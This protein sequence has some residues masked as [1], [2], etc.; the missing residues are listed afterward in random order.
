[1][2]TSNICTDGCFALAL[3]QIGHVL[4][5][6]QRARQICERSVSDL[7][8]LHEVWP[9]GLKQL[10]TGGHD[11]VLQN[12]GSAGLQLQAQLSQGLQLPLVARP[13]RRAIP[14]SSALQAWQLATSCVDSS[15][16]RQWIKE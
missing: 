15:Q 14:C 8:G 9:A 11:T 12:E 7:D 16:G 5:L 4:R 1:M 2:F 3:L 6:Q 13:A 10:R